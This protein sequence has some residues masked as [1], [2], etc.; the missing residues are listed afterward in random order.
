MVHPPVVAACF[1]KAVRPAFPAP[2]DG[3]NFDG[4]DFS[5]VALA[6]AQALNSRISLCC[7]RRSAH[8]G[9]ALGLW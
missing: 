1:A 7:L 6:V 3:A 5:L 8:M 4:V 2:A 9:S